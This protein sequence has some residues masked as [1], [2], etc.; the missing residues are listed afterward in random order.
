MD[1]PWRTDLRGPQP[2]LIKKRKKEEELV[3]CKDGNEKKRTAT[4]KGLLHLRESLS[5]S[6]DC[7]AGQRL[8]NPHHIPLPAQLGESSVERRGSL[9]LRIECRSGTA[10]GPSQTG[11][12]RVTFRYSGVCGKSLQNKLFNVA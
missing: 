11:N 10:A 8:Q 2:Q 6:N 3:Y 12:Q 5:V 7:R 4:G 9:D 1:I